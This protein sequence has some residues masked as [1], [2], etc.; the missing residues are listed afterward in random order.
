MSLLHFCAQHSAVFTKHVHPSNFLVLAVCCQTGCS[1]LGCT[2]LAAA[3]HVSGMGSDNI[4]I[5]PG[6]TT[7]SKRKQLQF[8]CMVCHNLSPGLNVVTLIVQ[9][10]GC[11]HSEFSKTSSES[12]SFCFVWIWKKVFLLHESKFRNEL[13]WKVSCT[14]DLS[15]FRIFNLWMHHWKPLKS[16][17][18]AFDFD[19]VNSRMCNRHCLWNDGEGFYCLHDQHFY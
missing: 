14:W 17:L 18:L 4:S 7:A 19:S 1:R 16:A 8:N 2:G 10:L 6:D 12:M 9:L 13:N 11:R 5:A 3:P 15:H